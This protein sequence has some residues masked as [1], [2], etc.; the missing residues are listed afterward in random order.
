MAHIRVDSRRLPLEIPVGRPEVLSSHEVRIRTELIHFY[1]HLSEN[2]RSQSDK[3]TKN[4]KK[5]DHQHNNT[6][7]EDSKSTYLKNVKKR[8]A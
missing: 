2:V 8:M 3:T 5:E 4:R 7:K 1:F 6:I